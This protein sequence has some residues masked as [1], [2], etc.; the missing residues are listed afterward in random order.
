MA[1]DGS[2]NEYECGTPGLN[3]SVVSVALDGA[4]PAATD[5]DGE[6]RR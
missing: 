1:S 3:H 2:A 5:G 4:A 6:G